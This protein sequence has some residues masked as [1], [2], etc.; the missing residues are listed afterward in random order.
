MDPEGEIV[1]EPATVQDLSNWANFYDRQ[2]FGGNSPEIKIAIDCSIGAGGC[3][4][5]DNETICIPKDL[6]PFEKPCRIVLL[7]EMVHIKLGAENGDY[8]E[9]HGEKFQ[10]EIT[11]L[12]RNGAYRNLL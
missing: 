3:F 11:R 10:S 5:P 1:K 6:T 9:A 4:M 7:H 12:W 8:D 2:Y